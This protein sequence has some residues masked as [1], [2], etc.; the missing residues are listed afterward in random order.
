MVLD[1]FTPFKTGLEIGVMKFKFKFVFCSD[2]KFFALVMGMKSASSMWCCPWCMVGKH[3]RDYIDT[4]WG[5][6]YPRSWESPSKCYECHKDPTKGCFRL[7][8]HDFDTNDNLLKILF[9]RDNCVLDV[10]H[11]ILRTSEIM[12]DCLMENATRYAVQKKLESAALRNCEYF[13]LI[14]RN[15]KY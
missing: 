12:E 11:M 3:H 5:E 10:L 9:K 2:W 7:K 4:D 6:Q 13:P 14:A 8:N 1:Q 15:I